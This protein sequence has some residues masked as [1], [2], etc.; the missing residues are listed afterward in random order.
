MPHEKKRYGPEIKH[1]SF[2]KF[3]KAN[4]TDGV[5]DSLTSVDLIF[6]SKERKEKKKKKNPN[7]RKIQKHASC[8]AVA[9]LLFLVC[10]Q[11]TASVLLPS[12]G[13][14]CKL[15]HCKE[16]KKRFHL[17]R[18]HEVILQTPRQPGSSSG[19]HNEP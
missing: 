13:S 1:L 19:Q 16:D 15:H 18:E 17:Q 6:D 4:F 12:T 5:S 7:E 8:K 2:S 10:D 9:L 11:A 3:S 14:V